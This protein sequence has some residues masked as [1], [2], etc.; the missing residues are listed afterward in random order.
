MTESPQFKSYPKGEINSVNVKAT[1]L[2]RGLGSKFKYNNKMNLSSEE[3]GIEYYKNN[4]YEAFFSENKIWN[5][6]FNRIFFKKFK[7]SYYKETG[8]KL[9][10]NELNNKFY[11]SYQNLINK[12]LEELKDYNL[13]HLIIG[14]NNNETRNQLKVITEYLEN[15]QILQIIE[16]IIQD[17]K[18]NMRG[19]PDLMIWNENELFFAEVKAKADELS[20]EQIIT[21]NVLLEVGINITFFSI[22]K[23]KGR[24]KRELN[25]YDDG[26]LKNKTYNFRDFYNERS[27]KDEKQLK[28]FKQQGK[29]IEKLDFDEIITL[30]K[31]FEHKKDYKNALKIYK[32]LKDPSQE[33]L[34]A[35]KLGKC[36]RGLDDFENAMN[37]YFNAINNKDFN[38]KQQNHFKRKI[39]NFINNSQYVERKD[40]EHICPRCGEKISLITMYSP[41]KNIKFFMCFKNKC[42]WHSEIVEMESELNF[43]NISDLERDKIKEEEK[44][45]SF[46]KKSSLNEVEEVKINK[47]KNIENIKNPLDKAE[48]LEENQQYKEATIIYESLLKYHKKRH[49]ILKRLVVCYKR[50]RQFEKE[51]DLT[52]NSMNDNR[53]S[54]NRKRFFKNRINKFRKDSNNIITTKTNDKCPDCGSNIVIKNLK[55]RGNIKFYMCENKDC[56]WYGGIIKEL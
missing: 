31:I 29:D 27:K 52:F 17:Y 13:T 55:K 9:N 49:L 42:F 37:I 47:I 39:R 48:A 45:Q 20:Q 2:N 50:S 26:N 53:L 8:K 7:E 44:N 22:N 30:G 36:Y 34:K 15:D 35:R 32:Q 1:K 51:I 21:H 54:D 25:E 5:I 43:K 19:F 46:A 3:V 40:T 18:K 14:V 4:G 6:L 33:Y 12:V 38:I 41:K 10:K 56:Y 11:I 24:I 28:I 23:G 16:H